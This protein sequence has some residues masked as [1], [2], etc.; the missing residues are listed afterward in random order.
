MALGQ[1]KVVDMKNHD[2]IGLL[3]QIQKG[4]IDLDHPTLRT[5]AISHYIPNSIDSM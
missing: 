2:C 5:L 1:V 3:R 4:N